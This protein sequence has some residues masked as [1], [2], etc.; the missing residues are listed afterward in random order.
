MF[1]TILVAVDGSGHAGKAVR[2]AGDLAKTYGATLILMAVDGHRPLKGPL[3]DLANAEDLS[4]AEVFDRILSS[5]QVLAEV[6]AGVTVE[7]RVGHGDPADEILEEAGRAGADL[8]VVGRRGLGE[9]AE[10]LLGSVSRKVLH[11]AKVPVM[12]AHD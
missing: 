10:L 1:K 8:I 7:R 9:Y 6:P 3:A 4:R 5:A 12:V 2:C 11:L